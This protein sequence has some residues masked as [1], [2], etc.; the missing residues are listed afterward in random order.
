MWA[1][2]PREGQYTG[3]KWI[4][5][6]GEPSSSTTWH[7]LQACSWGATRRGT[8]NRPRGARAAT[9]NPPCH[10][11]PGPRTAETMT[12]FHPARAKEAETEASWAGG[13]FASDT[14]TTSYGSSTNQGMSGTSEVAFRWA[15]RRKGP[16]WSASPKR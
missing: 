3:K 14:T 9:R 1:L 5:P 8:R 7:H 4:A 2:E 10:P 16:G 6:D 12:A 11:P 15:M 13:I